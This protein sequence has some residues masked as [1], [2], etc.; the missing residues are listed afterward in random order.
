MRDNAFRFIIKISV[1][2]KKKRKTMFFR[3]YSYMTNF[4]QKNSISATHLRF[5][6]NNQKESTEKKKF[7]NFKKYV[8]PGSKR[9]KNTN[10]DFGRVKNKA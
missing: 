3:Y 7:D 2:Q 6:V 5:G 4:Y 1:Q 9:A 10:S 8:N